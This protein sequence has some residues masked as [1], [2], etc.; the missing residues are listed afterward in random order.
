MNLNPCSHQFGNLPGG[1][2]STVGRFK[3]MQHSHVSSAL[4]LIPCFVYHLPAPLQMPRKSTR[5]HSQPAL[6][7]SG[8]RSNRLATMKPSRSS[9]TCSHDFWSP[10]SLL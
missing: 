10:F 8:D 5:V 7:E 1:P 6:S 9:K 4:L 2:L 3:Q